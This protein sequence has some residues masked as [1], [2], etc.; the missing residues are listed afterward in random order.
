M[1]VLM[2]NQA[3]HVNWLQL[4]SHPGTGRSMKAA[5]RVRTGSHKHIVIGHKY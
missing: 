3:K 2:H 5:M 1:Q 4:S